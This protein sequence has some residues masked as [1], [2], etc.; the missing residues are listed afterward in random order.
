MKYQLF[1]WVL[2]RWPGICWRLIFGSQMLM[3]TVSTMSKPILTFYKKLLKKESTMNLKNS[4]STLDSEKPQIVKLPKYR[5]WLK[6]KYIEFHDEYMDVY[7]DLRKKLLDLGVARLPT[8]SIEQF[9]FIEDWLCGDIPASR[10]F[11]IMDKMDI[12]LVAKRRIT[13]RFV[14][15]MFTHEETAEYVKFTIQQLDE[16]VVPLYI[17]Y[18][19]LLKK[20][21]EVLTRHE[22]N[23]VPITW[24]E[25]S[26]HNGQ[27][28][29]KIYEIP[30]NQLI[31]RIDYFILGSLKQK[32]YFKD[33]AVVLDEQVREIRYLH[34]IFGTEAC[35]KTL[36]EIYL[37]Q[38]ELN[39]KN[40]DEW[41]YFQQI[42]RGS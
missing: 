5:D 14:N 6:K 16:R 24:I 32:F 26:I 13:R 8:S 18:L 34:W 22:V 9:Q 40:Q 4:L 23:Q 2:V 42:L 15:Y 31:S 30:L 20:Y 35:I 27:I 28:E 33:A 36:K 39:D 1:I 3:N 21:F 25:H 11:E 10:C 29:T 37:I 7:V 41:F 12:G 19:N 17:G 38:T